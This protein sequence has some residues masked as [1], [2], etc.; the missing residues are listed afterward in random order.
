MET[1]RVQVQQQ[2]PLPQTLQQEV[3]SVCGVKVKPTEPAIIPAG[4]PLAKVTTVVPGAKVTTME[5][6][7]VVT[8][9]YSH[10][11]SL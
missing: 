5:V 3:A 2:R 6:C 1:S 7:E 11:Q 10:Y 9:A 8:L 4:E